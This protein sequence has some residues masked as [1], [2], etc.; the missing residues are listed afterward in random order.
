[1]LSDPLLRDMLTITCGSNEA[2]NEG[3]QRRML[4][5]SL[6]R[7]TNGQSMEMTPWQLLA[8]NQPNL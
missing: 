8:Y 2:S 4:V 7:W 1:M 3:L 6:A 5:T